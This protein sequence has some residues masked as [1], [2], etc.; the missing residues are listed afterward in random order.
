MIVRSSLITIR[1]AGWISGR[2]VSSRDVQ[3]PE[4]QSELRPVS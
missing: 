4:C 2:K 1:F 3:E